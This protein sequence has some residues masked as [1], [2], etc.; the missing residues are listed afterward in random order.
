M[1]RGNQRAESRAKN[2]KKLNAGGKAKEGRPEQRNLSDSAALAEKVAR[3]AEMKKAQEEDAATN[4]S[5]QP[6]VRKKVPKKKN[7]DL[8]DL[9]GAGLSKVSKG[10][11]KW[12][13][14]RDSGTYGDY[15]L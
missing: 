9:L 4:V 15:F 8:D 14:N 1:A 2:E 6:V 12:F 11:K 10:K 13:G 3:K 7:D 5:S